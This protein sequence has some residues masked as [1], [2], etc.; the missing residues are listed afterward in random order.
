MSARRRLADEIR[1]QFTGSGHA[2]RT[3]GDAGRQV[4]RGPDLRQP[5]GGHAGLAGV[6]ITGRRGNAALTAQKSYR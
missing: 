3:G 6:A 4:H 1:R 2:R 5:R